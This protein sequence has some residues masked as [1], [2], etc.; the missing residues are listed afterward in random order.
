MKRNLVYLAIFIVVIVALFAPGILRILVRPDG[1]R[2]KENAR[3]VLRCE[4]NDLDYIGG[5]VQRETY[6]L[7]S[8]KKGAVDVTSLLRDLEVE[9]FAMNSDMHRM[10][11]RALCAID[12]DSDWSG[13]GD[14]VGCREPNSLSSI[15][16]FNGKN[17]EYVLY[18]GGG[19]LW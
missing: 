13:V 4:M 7:F 14:V 6:A 8:L 17:F 5:Y 18:I 12:N 10:V 16:V 9:K 19:V 3:S 11:T 2:I 15:F 1:D